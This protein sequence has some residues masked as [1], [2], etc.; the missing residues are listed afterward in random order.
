[1][2]FESILKQIVADGPGILGA[3]LVGSDGLI[4]GQAQ[5]PTASEEDRSEWDMAA[6]GAELGRTFGD[7]AM[8][9]DELGAGGAAELMVRLERLTLM[10][11]RIDEEILLILGLTPDGN[12]GKARYLMRREGGAIRQEI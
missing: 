3:A 4:I 10:G 2:S 6:L 7:L 12:I 8:T 1:M 11:S 5:G 9:S